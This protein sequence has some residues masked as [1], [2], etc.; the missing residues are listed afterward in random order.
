MLVWKNVG[1]S[2]PRPLRCAAR[3]AD[4]GI[5]ADPQYPIRGVP[6]QVDDLGLRH[7]GHGPACDRAGEAVPCFDELVLRRLVVLEGNP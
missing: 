7:A 3:L 6:G 1:Q 5:G 2:M 4:A